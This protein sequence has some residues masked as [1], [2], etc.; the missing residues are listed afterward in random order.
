[1]TDISALS[2]FSQAQTAGQV[3]IAVAKKA[4]DSAR[5]QG[6]AAIKLLESAA[7]LQQQNNAAGASDKGSIIDVTA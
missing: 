6:D 5:A 7:E 4:I 1:M 3:R 2:S